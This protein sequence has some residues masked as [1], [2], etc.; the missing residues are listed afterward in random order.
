MIPFGANLRL[1]Y[2][3]ETLIDEF[4]GIVAIDWYP[5]KPPPLSR[6]DRPEGSL[7]ICV[8]VPGLGCL[9]TDHYVQNYAAKM[10][11]S[12]YYTVVVTAR[13]L[14]VPLQNSMAWHPGFANDALFTLRHI[15]CLYGDDARIFMTGFSAG[16]SIILQCLLKNEKTKNPVKVEGVCAVCVVGDY[17]RVR[18]NLQNSFWGRVYSFLAAL[19][20]KHIIK[21]NHHRLNLNRDFMR[22][23]DNTLQA[24]DAA[25]CKTVFGLKDDD[26]LD[27]AFSCRP[28]ANL[29]HI[30]ILVIQPADD[31][32]HQGSAKINNYA[33]D[34]V[35][36]HW[37]LIYVETKR[38]NHF[39]FVEGGLW[40]AFTN[41]KSYTYPARC[42]L[43]FFEEILRL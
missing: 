1:G 28:I 43:V 33:E 37:R 42:S 17:G 41:V 19:K 12:S 7:R 35:R 31:P 23:C 20:Y 26:N 36:C 5:I 3:R 22:D 18:N 34:F 2:E 14:Q 11:E 9:S 6:K 4:G 38:G 39:G 32:F 10:W 15:Q 24:V 8:F 30:P 25:A 29:T 13:G 40:E 27:W 16:T 21:K